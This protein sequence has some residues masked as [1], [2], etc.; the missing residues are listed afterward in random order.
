MCGRYRQHDPGRDGTNAATTAFITQKAEDKLEA[1][2][3]TLG[4]DDGLIMTV[5]KLHN[6]PSTEVAVISTENA[7]SEF[8]MLAC[9]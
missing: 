6:Y 3:L 9:T 8:V 5:V 1:T 4:T 2:A 7:A